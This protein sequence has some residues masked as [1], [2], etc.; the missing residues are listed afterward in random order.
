MAADGLLNSNYMAI[1]ET[2]GMYFSGPDIRY[3][4][5]YNQSTGKT[6]DSFLAAY[7]EEWGE[8]PAA[9][10]WAHSYDATTLLLDAIAAASYDDDGTLVID[11][12]GV[13]EHLNNVTDYSGI[14]GLIT[15]DA[16]G[17]CGSQKITVIGHGDSTDVAAS[18]ANV[19]Y[20]YAPGG[21]A[22]GSGDLVAPV[23]PVRGGTM[24]FASTQVGQHVNHGVQSGIGIAN[25]SSKIYASLMQM[26]ENWEPQPYLAESWEVSDDQMTITIHITDKATFHDGVPITS[27]DVAFSIE[28]VK[29]NHPFTGMWGP[30]ESM[31]TP[32]DT[33]IVLNLANPHPALWI[34]MSD[35]MLPIMP[36]HVLGDGS[37]EIDKMKEHPGIKTNVVGSGPFMFSDE[38]VMSEKIILE[39]YDDFWIP[40][41]PY[42]DKIV[43]L[44]VSDENAL[45][46]GLES[47]D[48]D[49]VGTASIVN[50]KRFSENED[51][52]FAPD[53]LSGVGST[54]ELQFNLANETMSDI[55]VRQAIAYAIDRDFV[56]QQLHQGQTME[57]LGGIHPSSPFYN[58]DVERYDV[59]LDKA[60]ALLVEAGYADGLELTIDYIPGPAEQQR[61]VAEYIARAVEPI[62]ITL[63]VRDADS[64]PAW[65]GIFFGGP[66][67]WHMTMNAYFNWGDPVI[68]VQRAYVCSNIKPGVFVNNSAYCNEKVDELLYAAAAATSIEERT[69]LYHEF[70]EIT[71]EELPFYY[72]N[73]LPIFA[74]HQKDVMNLPNGP[75][76]TLSNMY[77][78]WLDR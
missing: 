23:I 39:A 57:Q 72:I 4:A 5:N 7:T 14:I 75:W 53:Y 58:A 44:I 54:N 38:S 45:A 68:G 31:D 29:N 22:E 20:E 63:T 27:A 17:D 67:A 43:Y 74:G 15:C 66:D 2:E 64:L 18:N 26:D 77:S 49:L 24:V 61:N 32:D 12:A 9:P 42:L 69:A 25:L 70:Q 51:L 6:A 65:A 40:G 46:L 47:G 76:S 10:F 35:V 13:R 21:S 34:A 78:V 71:A 60:R 3:G 37:V 48:Y 11:R 59:D 55:R 73:A 16:F 33:T 1:P 62:G 8:D 28:V 30:L 36:K 50:A 19:V 41:R 56:T 52:T